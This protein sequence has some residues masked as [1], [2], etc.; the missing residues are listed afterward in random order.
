M[1]K[2]LP[3]FDVCC[4]RAH[5]IRIIIQTNATLHFKIN[6][7]THGIKGLTSPFA[8]SAQFDYEVV[9]PNGLKREYQRDIFEAIELDKP[10]EIG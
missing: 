1:I 3:P 7:P 5:N 2:Y 10:A 8:K 9:L 4:E 6:C